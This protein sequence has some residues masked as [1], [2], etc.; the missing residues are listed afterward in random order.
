MNRRL[1]MICVAL[2][3]VALV[4]SPTGFSYKPVGEL[5]RGSGT[6]RNDPF[7]YLAGMRFPLESAPA[8]ANSQVWGRGG[9]FGGG[10][11]QCDAPNYSYPWRDTYCE[12]RSWMMPLCPATTGH[13]G[14]DIRPATCKKDVHWV[15][16][17]ASGQIAKVGA[18]SVYLMADSG[19]RIDY[20]HMS[21][22]LVKVGDRMKAGARIGKVSNVF[23]GTP[24]TIHLHFNLFQNVTGRGW[25]YVP[26]YTSLVN[27]YQTLV[28]TTA[29]GRP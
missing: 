11:G 19:T 8:F 25:I 9:A 12:S 24:T 4:A 15:V 28:Q 20:L 3:P 17:A 2:I 29:E 23:N 1:A 16:A 18:Y 7:V 10:G 27:A 26:P 21:S 5:T 22:V 6:G 13:Q 14:Q